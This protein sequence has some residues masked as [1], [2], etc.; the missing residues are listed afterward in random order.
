LTLGSIA[1]ASFLFWVL[2]TLRR[3]DVVMRF[4]IPL[5]RTSLIHERDFYLAERRRWRWSLR[6]MFLIMV[7]GSMLSIRLTAR[8]V[9]Y[10]ARDLSISMKAGDTAH[11]VFYG[12]ATNRFQRS[13][14]ELEYVLLVSGQLNGQGQNIGTNWRVN[15]FVTSRGE[16]VIVPDGTQLHAIVDGHAYT[17]NEKITFEEF[18]SFIA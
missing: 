18:R 13:R 17:R 16:T 6:S 3:R 1:G 8:D 7:V 4:D 15:S 9:L 2:H 5:G 10:E 12:V 11:R 14:S